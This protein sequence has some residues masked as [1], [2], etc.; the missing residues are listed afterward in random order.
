MDRRSTGIRSVKLS[1]WY[2]HMK[3]TV[4]EHLLE[5][6]VASSTI[7]NISQSRFHLVWLWPC[8]L[9]IAL[10]GS[11]S[12]NVFTHH[13]QK[14]LSWLPIKSYNLWLKTRGTTGTGEEG[15]I[16]HLVKGQFLLDRRWLWNAT[17]TLGPFLFPPHSP[18]VLNKFRLINVLH[19]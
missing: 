3:W 6:L 4:P 5:V 12:L 17:Q 7:S 11:L 1:P 14:G 9:D 13:V 18:K 16:R 8:S 19:M 10:S 2:F 15:M